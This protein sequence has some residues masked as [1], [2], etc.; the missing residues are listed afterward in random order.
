MEQAVISA[1]RE[2]N[3]R[4]RTNLESATLAIRVLL[5]RVP[6]HNQHIL[7]V[8]ERS[9]VLL[10]RLRDRAVSKACRTPL[11][12]GQLTSQ[13]SNRRAARRWN[14]GAEMTTS[15]TAGGAGRLNELGVKVWR[16]W[17]DA[18]FESRW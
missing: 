1:L 5:V 10:L 17:K 11:V 4:P 18:L 13:R 15:P 16:R 3:K 9:R 2:P 12:R 14:V 6:R 7:D 8:A